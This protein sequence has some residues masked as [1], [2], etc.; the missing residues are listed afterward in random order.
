[1]DSERTRTLSLC[2]SCTFV[3][4]VHGRGDHLY[5]LCRNESIAAK[6]PRQP[7]RN[8]PGFKGNDDHLYPGKRLTDA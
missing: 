3:K 7:V 8:C 4:N 5:Y 1:V 2:P 6:Y